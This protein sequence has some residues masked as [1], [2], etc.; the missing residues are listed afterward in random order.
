MLPADITTV[1]FSNCTWSFKGSFRAGTQLRFALVSVRNMCVRVSVCVRV[2]GSMVDPANPRESLRKE[3]SGV[4]DDAYHRFEDS[5]GDG[6][7]AKW[8]YLK[9]TATVTRR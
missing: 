9:L 8:N 4:A 6:H 3:G 7:M 5:E 1:A 2:A